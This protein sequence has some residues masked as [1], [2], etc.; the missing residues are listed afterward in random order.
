MGF[1]IVLA[2]Y[3]SAIFMLGPLPLSKAG[4]FDDL[5]GEAVERG[6]DV[7]AARARRD[8]AEAS[9][10][11]AWSR[12]LPSIK[13]YGEF[14]YNRNNALGRMKGLDRDHFDNSQYG[15]S[16]SLPIYRGGAN[17][18]GLKE[19]R[20]RAAAEGHSYDEVRQLLLLDTAR[21]MLG[22]IRD[23]EIVALQRE[24]RVIVGAILR[25]TKRRFEG[26]EATRTDIE[27]ARDQYTAVQSLYTQSIDNL[28]QN[29]AEFKR[30]IG[31][32]AGRLAPPRG[33][34]SRLPKSL[35][36]ATALAVQ[37]NPQLLAADKRAA[38]A[39]HAVKGSYS[40]FL[41][42]VDLNMDYSEDRYHG[43]SAGD[44]S[45]FS[46]KLNFSVPL[47]QPD[48]LPSHEDSRHVSRQRQY[49][50]R[51]ARYQ[52][53]A[54][55]TIAW[56]SFH[57]ARKRYRLAQAR[58]KAAE[59]AAHGMRRE[60]EAGQR[61]VLDVLD[62]QERVVEAKVQASNAKFE[63]YMAGY[64]LLSAVGSLDIYSRQADDLSEYVKSAAESYKRGASKRPAARRK[65]PADH[66]WRLQEAR[67]D[68]NPTGSIKKLG[69]GGV[70]APA[71]EIKAQTQ[72][73]VARKVALGNAFIK[74]MERRQM[75]L[76]L[77]KPQ[78]QLLRVAEKTERAAYDAGP[79]Q[80]IVPKEVQKKIV[81]TPSDKMGVKQGNKKSE[82]SGLERDAVADAKATL[83]P[84]DK[85]DPAWWAGGLFGKVLAQKGEPEVTGSVKAVEETKIKKRTL[86]RSALK[87]HNIPLPIRKARLLAARPIKEP[88]V[89]GSI[90]KGAVEEF[91]DTYQNRF[92]V[93]WNKGVDKVIGSPSGAKKR[94]KLIPLDEY[95]AKRRAEGK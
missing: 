77:R 93:W 57:T 20:E 61:T 37:N 69:A 51:D 74:R 16:A 72:K 70:I 34:Y 21:A 43:S 71:G 23:R 67:L 79:P 10:N 55:A 76:P 54:M 11:K 47:Y 66:D 84:E 41:P 44:E 94:V 39:E 49:E 6:T 60:L 45:D 56:R 63:S 78:E 8:A 35:G 28:H 22:I 2:F 62:T 68:T 12:F 5:M 27:I 88:V 42:N 25:S 24:N 17:Y 73:T 30:L 59:A 29:E 1:M 38:A 18:Y 89:T 36:E 33:L 48:A 53:K 4:D 9:V 3:V 40:K 31:R 15:I 58:I 52:V 13:G 91:P 90:K 14:G 26:G 7:D 75:A 46:V 64:L 32:K 65:T 82:K 50:A 83:K 87:F 92:A 19:A 81:E 95:R 80:V 86:K 85:R